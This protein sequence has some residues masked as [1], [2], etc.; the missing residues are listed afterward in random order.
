MKHSLS[1]HFYKKM[2]SGYIITVVIL[3]LF[4]SLLIIFEPGLWL[5]YLGIVGLLFIAFSP[6]II[7]MGKRFKKARQ[8]E[9]W[10]MLDGKIIDLVPEVS[11]TPKMYL[12]A[13]VQ[14]RGEKCFTVETY[15]VLNP[16]TYSGTKGKEVQIAY[17]KDDRAFIMMIY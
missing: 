15:P 2:F 14:V 5:L 10:E 11:M 13:I 9:N 12:K 3:A 16:K 4:V 1:Y 17:K 7:V 6:F 8:A